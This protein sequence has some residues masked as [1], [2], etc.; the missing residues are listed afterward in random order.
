MAAPPHPSAYCE[1]I[2]SQ[3]EVVEGSKFNVD[4][5]SALQHT[6]RQAKKG[7]QVC[8]DNHVL[9]LMKMYSSGQQAGWKSPG[10]IGHR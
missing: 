2:T 3:L 10:H 7:L 4:H 8:R 6:T 1:Q 9:N 5:L